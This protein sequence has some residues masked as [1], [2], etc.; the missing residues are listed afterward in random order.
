MCRQGKTL[1]NEE[2]WGEVGISKY[3]SG[4]GELRCYCK[5][6]SKEKPLTTTKF[7]SVLFLASC[8]S[9]SEKPS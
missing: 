7:I 3:A 5:M 4:G 1:A 8:Y 6:E 9:F 2:L